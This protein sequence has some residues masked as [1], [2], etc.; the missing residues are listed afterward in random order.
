MTG[1]ACPPSVAISQDGG[2]GA[3]APLPTLRS[4]SRPRLSHRPLRQQFRDLNRVQ[5]RAFQELIGSCEYRNRMAGGIAEIPANA[6]DQDVILARCIDR[7]RKII[8]DPIV[9]DLHAGVSDRIART[10]SSVIGFSHSKVIAAQCARST[11]TRTQV[12]PTAMLSSSKIFRVSLMTLV[13]SS[14]W[15]V[16][17]SIAV[18]WL[19]R[20]KA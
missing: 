1:S 4:V 3:D 19:N 5:R 8:P 6:A 7:H 13:S 17:G 2:H 9:H 11:G 16:A 15:P 18:L 20:L 12:T 10:S 14:L